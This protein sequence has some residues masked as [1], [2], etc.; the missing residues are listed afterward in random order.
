MAW[1]PPAK[2]GDRDPSVALA[3]A[4]LARF[5]YG[6]DLDRSDL[7][8]DAFGQALKL[9]QLYR[10]REIERGT[11]TGPTMAKS[12][13]LDWA[14][15]RQLGM[16]DAPPAPVRGPRHPA[17]VWRGTGGIPGLDYTSKVCQ[18]N[19]DLVEEINTP[20]SATMGG[21]PV[22]TAGH[23][24]DPSMWRG[25]RQAF[26]DFKVDFLRRRSI[27]PLIRGVFG[28][29]SAGAVVAALSREWVL[30]HYPENYLCSFSLGDPTRPNG[31]AFYDAPASAGEGQG[32]S[33]WQYGDI[34][35]WRHC[36]L[37]NG[38]DMYGRVP[39]GKTGEILQDGFDLVTNVEISDP[40]AT[41]RNLVQVIPEIAAD[42]GI[43]IPAALGALAGGPPAILAFGMPLV[44]GAIGGLIGGGNPDTL[45]GTAAAAAAASIALGFALDNPPTRPHITYEYAEVW[46]GQTYLGLASQHVRD[47]A[48]RIPAVAA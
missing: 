35:D 22:G 38:A 14:T 41:A 19:A 5:E 11:K 47:Y 16:L 33:S 6:H 40:I 48:T 4:K 23:L 3:K 46:P 39:L 9:F 27:N 1:A 44:L 29:Y 18:A 21:I 20:W 43:P 12:G 24:W 13:V 25:A 28:G 32:I 34:D 2:I 45:T 30:E 26:E 17:W 10:N 8:T 15:K 37:T 31:G 42:S 36:W 7:Y